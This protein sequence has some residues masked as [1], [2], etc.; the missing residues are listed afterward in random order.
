MKRT[1]LFLLASIF[2]ASCA[3]LRLPD[4]SNTD[5]PTTGN[6]ILLTRI[7][8]EYEPQGVPAVWITIID[9]SNIEISSAIIPLEGGENFRAI[10][11]PPGHYS[12][13]G[14]YLGGGYSSEFRGKLLFD[15]V[16]NQANYVGD[17]DLSIDWETRKYRLNVVDRSRIAKDR[18]ESEYPVAAQGFPFVTA[19]TED[20]RSTK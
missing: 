19:I 9:Q 1:L 17:I 11:L 14:I 16:A 15:V 7:I 4:I 18:Y 8:L 12:W 2:L 6:G 3:N 20:R 13:R 5:P 10:E